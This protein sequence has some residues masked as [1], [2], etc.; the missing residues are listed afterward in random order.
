MQYDWLKATRSDYRPQF[1]CAHDQVVDR[2]A[3]GFMCETSDSS[4]YHICDRLRHITSN[5][6]LHQRTKNAA[7]WLANGL[8]AW[9][10]TLAD[11]VAKLISKFQAFKRAEFSELWNAVLAPRVGIETIVCV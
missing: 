11:V 1:L 6:L 5:G 4:S 10:P 2:H 3:E 7:V 8:S 9:S